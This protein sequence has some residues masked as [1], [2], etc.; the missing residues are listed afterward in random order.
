[1]CVKKYV[2]LF[3][4]TAGIL[5]AIF[6]FG[7]T[8]K[9]P[10]QVEMAVIQARTVSTTVLCSGTVEDSK[11]YR[12]D[13]QIP[14]V[15][16]SILVEEGDSV[17][18]GDV[19]MTVDRK[20]TVEAL[21]KTYTGSESGTALLQSLGGAINASELSDFLRDPEKAIPVG[22]TLPEV[23]TAPASGVVR[24]VQAQPERLSGGGSPLFVVTSDRRPCIRLAVNETAIGDVQ[25]GQRAVITGTGFRHSVYSGSV[26]KIADIAT[27]RLNGISYETVVEVLLAVENP[28]P[29]LK[30]G[31]SA[32]AV[33]TTGS[34]PRVLTLPFRS[35]RTD[36]EGCEFV[37]RCIDGKAVRTPVALGEETEDGYTVSDG[38]SDGDVVILTPELVENGTEV[39]A[40]A[41]MDGEEVER[42]VE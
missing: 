12:V 9:E 23:I 42:H 25:L 19:L 29:D 21:L 8:Q 7:S 35:I 22:L 2:I 38:V 41:P 37:Y 15:A 4:A 3:A 17:S 26:V 18:K 30:P 31:L 28:G 34:R 33:I 1:M 24:A 10:Q 39:R 14:L 36:D 6:W 40:A 5:G 32:S 27:Q 13:S 11:S 20:A 16:E